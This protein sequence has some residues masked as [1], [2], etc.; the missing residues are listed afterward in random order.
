[1][2]KLSSLF[3]EGVASGKCIYNVKDFPFIESPTSLQIKIEKLGFPL[4]RYF[5]K[6]PV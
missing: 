6:A 2:E 4:S 1:M 3:L 5:I